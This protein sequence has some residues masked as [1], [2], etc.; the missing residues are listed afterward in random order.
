MTPRKN[1]VVEIKN[2]AMHEMAITTLNNSNMKDIFLVQE[3]HTT[4]CI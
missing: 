2:R 3:V 1:G 4:M